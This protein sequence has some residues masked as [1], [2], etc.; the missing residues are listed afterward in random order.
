[1]RNVDPLPYIEQ[2]T[3]HSQLNHKQISHPPP[4]FLSPTVSRTSPKDTQIKAHTHTQKQKKAPKGVS[5]VLM[6]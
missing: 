5:Q 2:P 4:P 6:A 3:G 1:M